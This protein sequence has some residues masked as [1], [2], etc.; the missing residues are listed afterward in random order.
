[1]A[2][3][4]EDWVDYTDFFGGQFMWAYRIIGREA[5]SRIKYPQL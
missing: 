1:M 5:P 4:Y 2:T 3:D